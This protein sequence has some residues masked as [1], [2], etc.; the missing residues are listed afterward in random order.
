MTENA[1]WGLCVIGQQSFT[2]SL[3]VLAAAYQLRLEHDEWMHFTGQSPRRL[4]ALPPCRLVAFNAGQPPAKRCLMRWIT[5]LARSP[6]A[7]RFVNTRR[8]A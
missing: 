2:H 8:L 3:C 4:A 5:G 6:D 1:V 7:K